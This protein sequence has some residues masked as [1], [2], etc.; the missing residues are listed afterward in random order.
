MSD[1]H[2]EVQ[3]ALRGQA[4]VAESEADSASSRQRIKTAVEL[5]DALRTK[6]SSQ[7]IKDRV[8]AK[9]L[10]P[11]MNIIKSTME[12]LHEIHDEL[13]VAPTPTTTEGESK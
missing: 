4:L 5:L 10:D 6:L 1:L 9:R 3:K 13:F 12:C 2:P 7:E 11:G 8:N